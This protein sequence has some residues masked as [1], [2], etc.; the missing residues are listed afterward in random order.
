MYPY[1]LIPKLAGKSALNKIINI[2]AEFYEKRRIQLTHFL[3]YLMKHTKLGKT[4]EFYKFLHDPELDVDFFKNNELPYRFPES[5]KL[6]N[7][8]TSK[9]YGVFSN[10]FTKSEENLSPSDK[11]TKIK[12]SGEFYKNLSDGLKEIKVAMVSYL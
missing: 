2:D 8:V 7:N 6:T 1:L 3:N 12:K 11:E 10:Y 5:E 4:K 9:I